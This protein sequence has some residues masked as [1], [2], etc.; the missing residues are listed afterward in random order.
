M[1][2]FNFFWILPFFGFILGY[3]GCYFF[4]HQE[5]TIL[6]NVIGR[7][8]QD[9]VAILSK[10][11][12]GTRLMRE[13]EDA[14][15]PEGVILDQIPRADNKIRLNQSV[16]V[17]ISKKP[18]VLQAPNFI[19]SNLKEV[20]SKANRSDIEVVNVGL[21]SSYP[22]NFCFAQSPKFGVQLARRRVVILISKGPF[23]LVI[24]PNFKGYLVEQVKDFLRK[25][26]VKC[27]IEH[28]QGVSDDHVCNLCHV[29]D[30]RPIPGSIISFEQ[31]VQIQLEVSD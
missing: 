2:K 5:S 21:F 26:D 7:S 17:T 31:Q 9:G 23:P 19:S 30:Q 15:L 13:Q 8:L 3:V 18:S 6:P 20:Q 22:N 24:V 14:S 10:H 11:R 12:L 25:S 1:K 4:M 28:V 27:E 29:T 16:F